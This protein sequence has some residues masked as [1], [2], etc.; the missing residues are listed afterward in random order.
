[1]PKMYKTFIRI[2]ITYGGES[3]MFTKQEQKELR[4]L[5]NIFMAQSFK[6]DRWQIRH[7]QE[8]DDILKH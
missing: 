1:M 6:N 5:F 3:W 4:K 2:I 8:T 7:N